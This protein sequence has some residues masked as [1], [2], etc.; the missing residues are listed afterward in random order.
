MNKQYWIE[1]LDIQG[2]RLFSLEVDEEKY[3]D[4]VE[5]LRKDNWTFIREILEVNKDDKI[6]IARLWVR[7][8]DDLLDEELLAEWEVVW[9]VNKYD[10]GISLEH[11]VLQFGL[12]DEGLEQT[13]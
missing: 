10:C 12:M 11:V 4:E 9:V 5:K 1:L 7:D 13:E 6:V 2:K 8:E 3:V